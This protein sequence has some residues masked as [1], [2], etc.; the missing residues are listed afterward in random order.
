M[1][2]PPEGPCPGPGGLSRP[3]RP[4]LSPLLPFDFF[5]RRS[6]LSL[7]TATAKEVLATWGHAMCSQ[8]LQTGAELPFC[9]LRSTYCSSSS[10]GSVS[11]SNPGSKSKPSGSP[12]SARRTQ[13]GLQ[14]LYCHLDLPCGSIELQHF[15]EHTLTRCMPGRTRSR[16]RRRRVQKPLT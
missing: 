8:E 11:L 10:S 16:R 15:Q 6:E 1:S 14:S 9:A 3:A 7:R 13:C 4:W 5:A 12:S 2:D